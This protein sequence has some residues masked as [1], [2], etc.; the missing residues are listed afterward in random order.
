MGVN[1]MGGGDDVLSST[2]DQNPV[3]ETHV[4]SGKIDSTSENGIMRR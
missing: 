4:H 3:T 1:P 2:V